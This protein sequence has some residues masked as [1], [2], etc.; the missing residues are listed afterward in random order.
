MELLFLLK[1]EHSL[2]E[3]VEAMEVTV[4]GKARADR[5]VRTLGRR[6][7]QHIR[8]APLPESLI[9][10]SNLALGSKA[11]NSINIEVDVPCELQGGPVSFRNYTNNSANVCE[12]RNTM[13]GRRQ[14]P[15]AS[16]Y[17]F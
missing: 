5:V 10:A 15:L 13:H 9:P 16:N 11:T 8:L 2:E 12:L 17:A 6:T 4:D 1:R 7:E 14:A 3:K